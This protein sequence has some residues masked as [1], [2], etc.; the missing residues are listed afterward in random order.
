MSIKIETIRIS[1]V[2]QC[3]K[4]T[5]SDFQ[6]ICIFIFQSVF[7]RQ[8]PLC[9]YHFS[10]L[11]CQTLD[12][13]YFERVCST[14]WNKIPKILRRANNFQFTQLDSITWLIFWAFFWLWRRWLWVFYCFCSTFNQFNFV[15]MTILMMIGGFNFIF[16][17]LLFSSI[18]QIDRVPQ[19][20]W[21]WC[22]NN[23]KIFVIVSLCSAKHN[24]I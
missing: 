3:I 10:S 1:N 22:G 7:H 8:L 23:N 15:R 20:H 2:A 5:V 14:K 17:L 13:N 11:N 4:A 21:V 19:P 9:I 6:T 12:K 18:S 24:S 16:L